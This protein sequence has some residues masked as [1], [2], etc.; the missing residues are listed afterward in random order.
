MSEPFEKGELK[1]LKG[2]VNNPL[3]SK[4]KVTIFDLQLKKDEGIPIT[5]LTAYDYSSGL[6]V[7]RA[8]VDVILVGD[9]L[10]MVML[11]ISSTIPITMEQMLHHCRAVAQGAGRSFLV[12]DMPFMSYQADISE[13]VRNAGRFLKEGEME[14]VKLEGGQEVCKT[15]KAIV[16][17][18][19]PV[20]GHIG[21]TPQSLS[22]LGGYKV[23]GKTSEA[24]T[25]LLRDAVSLEAAGCYAIVL[26]AMPAQVAEVISSRLHIP[27][28][29]IGAGVGCDGQVLVYHD[30]LGLFDR[31]T[32]KFVKKYANL[33]PI[34]SAAISEF[35]SEVEN[36]SFPA[37]EYTYP[38]SDDELQAFTDALS[39]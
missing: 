22:K 21:L 16:N 2:P 28:I 39:R 30:L 19:I 7:D 20:M 12:G 4:S 18:G 5:M 33:A 34:I 15:I 26:E 36:K 3:D 1:M 38:I 31:F 9:S 29:G 17:A 8:G 37:E 27:T 6:Y 10:A 11:G 25:R 14:S 32:P 24:A 35:V 23:Q 13:A